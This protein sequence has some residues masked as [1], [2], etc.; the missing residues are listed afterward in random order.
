MVSNR[1]VSRICYLHWKQTYHRKLSGT[2]RLSKYSFRAFSFSSSVSATLYFV[3]NSL[4]TKASSFCSNPFCISGKHSS[5]YSKKYLTSAKNSS[6]EICTFFIS[7]SFTLSLSVTVVT[8]VTI[9]LLSYRSIK[10]RHN[11][12]ISS[13]FFYLLHFLIDNTSFLYQHINF[14][15][16]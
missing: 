11:R 3:Y 5:C 1:C 8:V 16:L 9:F 12:H 4:I 14:Q 10:Y 13:R 2:P 6:C 15:Y 7:R